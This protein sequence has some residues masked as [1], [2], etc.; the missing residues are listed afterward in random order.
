MQ[1]DKRRG[2]NWTCQLEKDTK[3]NFSPIPMV[4][5]LNDKAFAF[6]WLRL[7]K[8]PAVSLSSHLEVLTSFNLSSNSNSALHQ[9]TLQH[10]DPAYF[11]IIA[12]TLLYKT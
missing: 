2:I 3:V 5:Q 11:P 9:V 8:F 1:E 7:N 4:L 10:P 12:F 6:A